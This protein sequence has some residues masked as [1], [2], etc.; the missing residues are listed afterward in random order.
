MSV[1]FG[2]NLSART[3]SVSLYPVQMSEA[4]TLCFAQ[5]ERKLVHP[6]GERGG[7]LASKDQA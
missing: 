6:R 3:Q 7:G 2:F 5:T 4:V 1:L